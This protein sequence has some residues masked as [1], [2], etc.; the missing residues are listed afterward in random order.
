MCE[1]VTAQVEKVTIV[2]V[3]EVMPEEETSGGWS[4][5][6]SIFD[7]TDY[8]TEDETSHRRRDYRTM[9]WV[10]GVANDV[11]ECPEEQKDNA[12]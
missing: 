4:A 2:Q 8:S 5:D 3:E 9:S 1:I 7:W 6:D 12:K 11:V 10:Q